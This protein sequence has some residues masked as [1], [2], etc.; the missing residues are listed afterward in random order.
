ML[1]IFIEAIG[2]N[3]NAILH[4]LKESLTL[5]YRVFYWF[6]ASFLGASKRGFNKKV[7]FEQ[8]VFIGVKSVLM[9]AFISL[10]IGIVLAMQSASQ[11][12]RLRATIYVAGFVAVSVTREIGPVLVALI[13][14]G[15][16]GA[17]I[18]AE[19]ATM[20]VTEQIEALDTMALD[21][22]R[23][24][25]L[26]RFL[27]FLIMLPCLTMLGDVIAIFGGWLIGVTSLKIGSG[28]Y[29]DMTIRFLKMKDILTGLVKSGVF[30]VVISILSSQQGL[31]ATSGAKGVGR[32]TT[33]AV[34]YSFVIIILMDCILTWIFYMSKM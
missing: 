4:V 6:F 15:R 2:R 34:V 28:L 11:L 33:N 17:A 23:F 5:L 24:L 18:A 25:V 27:A 19:L 29:V 1:V 22:V 32:A 16:S 10:F 30:S 31:W 9:V 13:V 14:A 21:P 3:V 20:K 12:M 26:P 7:L 8:M